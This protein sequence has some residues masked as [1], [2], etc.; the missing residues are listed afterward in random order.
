M[1]ETISFVSSIVGLFVAFAFIISSC[2]I[3][4]P[5]EPFLNLVLT[6]Q[7]IALSPMMRINFPALLDKIIEELKFMIG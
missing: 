5:V 2:F 7:L 1:I 6:F 4:G 3:K